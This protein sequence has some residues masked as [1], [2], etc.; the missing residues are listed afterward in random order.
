M[1]VWMVIQSQLDVRAVV[2]EGRGVR[3]ALAELGRAVLVV[4]GP[5]QPWCQGLGDRG[6][7]GSGDALDDKQGLFGLWLGDTMGRPD[8]QM[9]RQVSHPQHGPIV[10]VGIGSQRGFRLEQLRL[11][12][13]LEQAASAVSKGIPGVVRALCLVTD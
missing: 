3:D 1:H 12:E 13:E 9:F 11:G 2:S 5:L 10:Q 7:G 6:S 4:C 8:G